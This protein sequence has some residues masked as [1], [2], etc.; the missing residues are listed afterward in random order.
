MPGVDRELHER[1]VLALARVAVRA[2]VLDAPDA[3]G[4]AR[5][6]DV[7]AVAVERLRGSPA[8]TAAPRPAPPGRPEAGSERPSPGGSRRRSRCRSS[9]GRPWSRDRRSPRCT[10]R[11]AQA[12]GRSCRREAPRRGPC[13]RSRRSRRD[14]VG[15]QAVAAD[16][17]DAAPL[18]RDGVV[19][20]LADVP[21]VVLD[22]RRV[23]DRRSGGSPSRRRAPRAARR[24]KG[25]RS[26]ASAPRPLRDRTCHRSPRRR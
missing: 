21:E 11:T 25:S 9:R 14:G 19:V 6:D 13:R 26:A 18:D 22:A 5:V 8:S 4:A 10:G 23:I 3:L 2:L 17:R 1:V 16:V 24:L 20:H 15:A 12:R 7:G